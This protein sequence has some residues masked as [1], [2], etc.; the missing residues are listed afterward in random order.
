MFPSLR[1]NKINRGPFRSFL[2]PRTLPQAQRKK[3]VLPY[4]PIQIKTPA[5]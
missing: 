1:L 4:S 3:R 5:H 2:Q